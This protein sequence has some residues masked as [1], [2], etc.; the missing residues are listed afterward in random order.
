MDGKRYHR[1][2]GKTDRAAAQSAAAR[3]VRA[4]TE[5]GRPGYVA[6]ELPLPE[7]I[8]S[9]LAAVRSEVSQPSPFFWDKIWDK[10]KTSPKCHPRFARDSRAL[11]SPLGLASRVGCR[12]RSG[13]CNL[14]GFVFDEL[15]AVAGELAPLETEPTDCLGELGKHQEE[16]ECPRSRLA[17]APQAAGDAD[18]VKW[19]GKQ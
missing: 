13:Q 1:S 16:G 8:G 11:A 4:V 14:G 18:H 2:T 15:R 7:L 3:L 9:W 17:F 6:P 12:R 5:G 10:S 19:V